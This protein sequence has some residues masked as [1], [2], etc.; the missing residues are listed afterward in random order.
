MSFAIRDA[1]VPV[2]QRGLKNLDAILAKAEAHA[3]ANGID[4][5][6]LLGAKLAPDMFDLKKQVQI[7]CDHAKGG[8][9]RLAGVELPKHPDT[10]TTF[11]ELH[12]RIAVTLE[13]ING[14]DAAKYD[15]AENRDIVLK[16]PWATYEFTGQ[17]FLTYWALPNFYFHLTTAYGI[18]R[19]NGV[20][21]GKAD[22]LGQ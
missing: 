2:F 17:K 20:A 11:A 1:S 9:G 5:A 4:A 22:F 13:F 18:L 15:G 16:F 3:V 21:L 19:S 10:E 6:T 8:C 7:A 14:I 12:A